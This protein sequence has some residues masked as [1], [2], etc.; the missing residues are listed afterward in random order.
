MGVHMISPNFETRQCLVEYRQK[1]L[2]HLIH[3]HL[4]GIPFRQFRA[5]G[6]CRSIFRRE[7]HLGM[8]FLT[9]VRS[10]IFC[11]RCWKS[12]CAD[13]VYPRIFAAFSTRH[14]ASRFEAEPNS[15]APYM[16]RST[17]R[18][19]VRYEWRLECLQGVSACNW[20]CQLCQSLYIA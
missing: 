16:G 18:G 12:I 9:K 1:Y 5:S 13:I 11:Y 15:L 10:S 17:P 7:M 2:K 3:R 14:L 4:K 6:G 8:T 20:T 19:L